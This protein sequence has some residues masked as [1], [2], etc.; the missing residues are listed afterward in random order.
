MQKNGRK[1]FGTFHLIQDSQKKN[2]H[3]SSQLSIHKAQS[4]P[5]KTIRSNNHKQHGRI[6]YLLMVTTYKN[7]GRI[8]PIQNHTTTNHQPVSQKKK[9]HQKTLIKNSQTKLCK[10]NSFFNQTFKKFIITISTK[11]NLNQ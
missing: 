5:I 10:Q 3:I 11:L 2:T 4:Y 1:S 9:R 8:M 7:H 6:M